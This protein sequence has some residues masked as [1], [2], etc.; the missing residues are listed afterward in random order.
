M[1]Q[2]HDLPYSLLQFY[3]TA[4]Y[5]CSYLPERQA[6]SQVATPAHLIDTPLYSQLVRDGFRRS[7]VYTYRPWCDACRACVPVRLPVEDFRPKRSQRRAWAQHQDL[8]AGEVALAFSEEHFELYRRY[9]RA[10]H[11]GGGMDQDDREQYA[12]FL[13]ESQV[14]TRLIEFRENGVLRMVSLI[15]CLSDG[16]SSVY[17]FYDPEVAGASYG[18]FGVLWQIASCRMIGRPWLYLGYWIR[19]CD[20]MNYKQKFRPL[21]G[22]VGGQWRRLSEGDFA[23][24]G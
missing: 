6:R 14:D 19:D 4:S 11:E 1:S 21:E 24:L 2:L 9:Q 8:L 22:R 23:Q 12:H 17:T 7:G 20:K 18:T 13:L 5:E 3:A 10:R 16:L 15:D